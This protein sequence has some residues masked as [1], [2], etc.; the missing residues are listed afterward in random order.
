MEP[1][2]MGSVVDLLLKEGN[3]LY[4]NAAKLRWMGVVL[5]GWIEKVLTCCNRDS[6]ERA[7]AQVAGAGSWKSGAQRRDSKHRPGELVAA[8]RLR[9]AKAAP[10]CCPSCQGLLPA[11]SLSTSVSIIIS[12]FQVEAQ[13]PECPC[14]ME[15]GDEQRPLQRPK[16]SR[17]QRIVAPRFRS[18]IPSIINGRLR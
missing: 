18:I 5:V 15:A 3:S 11:G 12:G 17:L 16:A 9:A 4:S 6:M 7:P 14:H 2:S 13:T 10:S 8:G 1:K